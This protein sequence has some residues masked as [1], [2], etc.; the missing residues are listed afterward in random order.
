MHKFNKLPISNLTFMIVDDRNDSNIRKQAEEELKRRC[1]PLGWSYV[2]LIDYDFRKITERG[3]DINKYLIGPKPDLQLLMELYFTYVYQRNSENLLLFSEKHLCSDVSY[4]S[5]FFDK[6][7]CRELEL[8]NMRI[9]N[10]PDL[11]VFRELLE[12]R[13]RNKKEKVDQIRARD[14][15]K[16]NELLQDLNESKIK[17]RFKFSDEF[18]EYLDYNDESLFNILCDLKAIFTDGMKLSEQRRLL[19]ECIQIGYKVDYHSQNMQKAL[20]RIKK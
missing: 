13:K 7:C 19:Q 6:V 8:I 20:V 4:F 16:Y 2:N 5:N 1:S 17:V 15:L 12:E 18:L 10:E 14:F 11:V 3:Y 9:K